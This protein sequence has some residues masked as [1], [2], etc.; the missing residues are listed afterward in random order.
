MTYGAWA[1]APEN[2]HEEVY[3]ATYGQGVKRLR[4]DG[5]Q[6]SRQQPEGAPRPDPTLSGRERTELDR[7]AGRVNVSLPRRGAS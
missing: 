7:L 5:G 1:K 4:R 6:A 3:R 2:A